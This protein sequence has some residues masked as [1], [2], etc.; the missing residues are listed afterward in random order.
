MQQIAATVPMA[1]SAGKK[2]KAEDP[3]LGG[4]HERGVLTSSKV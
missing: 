2:F 1:Q 4:K 3:K